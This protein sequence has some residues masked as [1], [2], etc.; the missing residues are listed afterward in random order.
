MRDRILVPGIPLMARVGCTAEERRQPQAIQVDIELSCELS[1]A[2]ESD[3]IEHAIDY[4]RV[5][6]EAERVASMRPYALIEAIAEGIARRL[7]E[8]F[9]AEE[10]LVRVRKPSALAGFGVP[11]AGVEVVR[12]HRG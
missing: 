2:A 9:P 6:D 11:W 4:V 5:R 10:V 3:S 12:G 1:R 8:A 7:L